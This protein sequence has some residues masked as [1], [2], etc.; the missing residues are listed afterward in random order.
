[1][2]ENRLKKLLNEQE[3]LNRQIE[4]ANKTANFAQGV[5]ERR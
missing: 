1:M 4:I 2:M 3:R 5:T